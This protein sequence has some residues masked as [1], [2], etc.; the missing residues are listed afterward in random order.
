LELEHKR[1]AGWKKA[2]IQELNDRAVEISMYLLQ[3]GR[4]QEAAVASQE[5]ER[6]HDV[7]LEPTEE[8]EAV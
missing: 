2:C 5:K 1:A 3:E 7:S 6:V 4:E 8:L